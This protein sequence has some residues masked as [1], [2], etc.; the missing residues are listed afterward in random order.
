VALDFISQDFFGVFVKHNSKDKDLQKIIF[1]SIKKKISEL[2]CKIKKKKYNKKKIT[3]ILSFFNKKV[4]MLN[5]DELGKFKVPQ[6]K[7]LFCFHILL[8]LA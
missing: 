5:N 3:L 4:F 2:Y 6:G 1:T 7:K 8:F